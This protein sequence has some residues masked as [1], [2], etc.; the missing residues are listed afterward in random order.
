MESLYYTTEEDI[1]RI[2]G[3]PHS[4]KFDGIHPKGKFGPRLYNKCLIS[5]IRTAGITPD[6]ERVQVQEEAPATPTSNMFDGL[7]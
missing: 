7:N 2:F 5:A 1:S 3:S 6:R 4:A